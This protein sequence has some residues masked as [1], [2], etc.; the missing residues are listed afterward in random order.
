MRFTDHV[1]PRTQIKLM[2]D[3]ILLN[4]INRDRMLRK[5]DTIIIDEAHE[6]S[7]TIDF[8]LGYLKQLLPKRPELKLIITS[9]T[10]DPD[11]FSR[12]FGDAPIVEVSGRTFPV[13]IR[14]RPLV[15]ETAL[16][17]D[18]DRRS[19]RPR[20][21]RWTRINAALDELAREGNGDVL[22][23]L[24][25]ESEIRD[26]E[27]AIRARISTGSI[28]ADT[29]VLPLYGRLSSAD[30]HK[31]FQPSTTP[32]TRRRIVLATNV[33]ETSLTVPGIKYVIDAGTA[34]I[35]PLQRRGRRSSGCRSRRSRRP[36]PT[37]APAAA[38]APA[39]ASPSA[40]TPR[41]ISLPAR[42]TPNRRSCAPTWPRSSCR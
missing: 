18:D 11:S 24:S 40:S 1:G 37:S 31:V 42:N 29:E 33:A 27:D 14:Y 35:S 25:G 2:T 9:A 3:G 4:E 21:I 34:R 22:V 36:P 38:A 13:E 6:R 17:E 41:R 8:L 20:S 19:S 12:H 23:F 39:T 30:Q 15:A 5:Y 7:L 26:T 10:I 16:D 32:G 28:S